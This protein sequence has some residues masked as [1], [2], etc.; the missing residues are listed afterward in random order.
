MQSTVG[1]VEKEQPMKLLLLGMKLNKY[2]YF[3]PT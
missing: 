2:E 3:L 1:K